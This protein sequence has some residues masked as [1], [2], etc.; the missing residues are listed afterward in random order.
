MQKTAGD[1]RGSHGLAGLGVSCGCVAHRVSPWPPSVSC[2][3]P[4]LPSVSCTVTLYLLQLPS[5]S[6]GCPQLPSVSCASQS[7]LQFF[8]SPVLHSVSWLPVVAG[9]SAHQLLYDVSYC[10]LW[11]PACLHSYPVSPMVVFS[12]SCNCPVSYVPLVPSCCSTNNFNSVPFSVLR[13]ILLQQVHAHVEA[14]LNF[15]ASVNLSDEF[16]NLMLKCPCAS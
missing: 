9:V 5:V 13:C 4:Q 2:G 8:I 14:K 3:C 11:L 6:C 10:L 12:V 1:H 7:L 15:A 16:H